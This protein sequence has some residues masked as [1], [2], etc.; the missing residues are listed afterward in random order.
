MLPNKRSAVNNPSH[1][2]PSELLDR[3]IGSKIWILM[4]GDKEI[5]GTLKG[6]DA[7]VNMVLE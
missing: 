3:C 6:F 7:Y 5:V 2:L 4:K 1:I